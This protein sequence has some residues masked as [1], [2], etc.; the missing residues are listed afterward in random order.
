VSER[1]KKNIGL[2]YDLLLSGGAP[3]ALTALVA[4]AGIGI[5]YGAY[6]LS[7]AAI[8]KLSDYFADKERDLEAQLAEVRRAKDALDDVA[9]EDDDKAG[10]M[11]MS[12]LEKKTYDRAGF[13]NA[14][15]LLLEYCRE[16]ILI[17]RDATS[18]DAE[19]LDELVELVA[20]EPSLADRVSRARGR[21]RSEAVDARDLANAIKDAINQ[22]SGAYME[23]DAVASEVSGLVMNMRSDRRPLV[24]KGAHAVY[25]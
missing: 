1:E 15:A 18:A 24:A 4:A 19:A 9:V 16:G 12:D 22:L 3:T 23:A 10:E 13:R 25:R 17:T 21:L 20:V 7:R 6:R 11:T 8:G 14:L 2:I 5:G